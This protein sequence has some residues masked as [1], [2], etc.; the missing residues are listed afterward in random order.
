M[1]RFINWAF[2]AL[3]GI[4]LSNLGVVEAATVDNVSVQAPQ[5]GQ[6]PRGN[7]QNREREVDPAQYFQNR[8][9][10]IAKVA[11]LTEEEKNAVEV[12]LK[13]YDDIRLQTWLET[14]KV[15]DDITLLGEKATDKQYRDSL[16]K[17]AD[18]SAKRQKANQEF[19]SWITQRL[20][21]KKAYLVHQSFRS[22]NA[23]TGRR[24]RQD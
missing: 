1:N 17:L 20:T 15:H 12:E 3:I 22:F 11:G 8:L 10:N 23:D 21:P 9:D 6:R 14:K 24:L 5:R 7:G 13:K 4:T 19:I 16:Q 18:L 2:I